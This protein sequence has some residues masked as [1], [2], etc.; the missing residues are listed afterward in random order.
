MHLA[1]EPESL[2]EYNSTANHL[3]DIRLS[4]LMFF[5]FIVATIAYIAT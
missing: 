2:D 5:T 3:T 4:C 1:S